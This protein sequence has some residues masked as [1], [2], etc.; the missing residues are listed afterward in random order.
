MLFTKR[1]QRVSRSSVKK[2]IRSF[3]F[4]TK[5]LSSDV[6]DLSQLIRRLH[7]EYSLK[8]ID[9]EVK[10]KI[11]D[12]MNP[13]EVEVMYGSDR[14]YE[15]EHKQGQSFDRWQS[16]LLVH[17]VVLYKDP[18]ATKA[19]NQHSLAPSVARMAEQ[20][21]ILE[22][23]LLAVSTKTQAPAPSAVDFRKV[24]LNK[25]SDYSQGVER[26]A[27][28]ARE[29]FS[30]VSQIEV[31]PAVPAVPDTIQKA[32]PLSIGEPKFLTAIR[33][34][35]KSSWIKKGGLYPFDAMAKLAYTWVGNHFKPESKIMAVPSSDTFYVNREG[36]TILNLRLVEHFNTRCATCGM[37]GHSSSHPDC[38]LK[39]AASAWTVCTTCRAGLHA[40]ADCHVL[41]AS[42]ENF[43]P[44]QTR[45]Y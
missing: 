8:A 17:N 25:A 1:T 6:F 31:A 30:L 33:T 19:V 36:V 40:E 15:R 32:R 43:R 21:Q 4:D 2:E 3:R 27:Q 37:S 35:L 10:T 39:N 44:G 5:T 13:S 11:E 22:A 23:K 42:I 9:N 18:N 16:E 20:L 29:S 41:L 24:D 45:T 34:F 28:I 26:G 12:Q 38:P 7:P 14:I